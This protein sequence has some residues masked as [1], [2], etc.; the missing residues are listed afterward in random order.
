MIT[1]DYEI[2][3]GVKTTITM[4]VPG[5]WNTYELTFVAKQDRNI[6]SPRV[7][8]KKN[9]LAGGGDNEMLVTYADGKTAIVITLEE[10]DTNDL[11]LTSLQYDIDAYDIVAERDTPIANGEIFIN[12]DVKTPFDGVSLP[13]TAIRVASI[14]AT[15][16]EV[17]NII[18][19]QLNSQGK[20]VFRFIT[21]AN[22][23]QQLNSI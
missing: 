15:D 17:G 14:F 21:L 2:Y 18:Q 4:V 12:H 11:V 13:A 19:I 10:A 6:S 20:K 5:A 7:I 16:G 9:L 22:L 1:A 8:E 3:R 23:K